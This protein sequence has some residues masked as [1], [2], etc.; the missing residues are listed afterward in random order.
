MDANKILN[1]W[2]IKERFHKRKQNV[3]VVKLISVTTINFIAMGKT[4]EE[5]E[6]NAIQVIKLDNDCMLF[7]NYS[8]N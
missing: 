5:A 2:G 6:A 1:I 7:E 8:Q 4:R 3:S